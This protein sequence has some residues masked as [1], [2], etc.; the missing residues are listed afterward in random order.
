[1]EK[2][3]S[4]PLITS[5][6]KKVQENFFQ[7]FLITYCRIKKRERENKKRKGK[8]RKKE[9]KLFSM[10]WTTFTFPLLPWPQ[11]LLNKIC[12][13]WHWWSLI[14]SMP[15][16]FFLWFSISSTCWLKPVPALP[17]RPDSKPTNLALEVHISVLAFPALP[18]S[19][20]QNQNKVFW[21]E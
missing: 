10:S 6:N 3:F 7:T 8:K 20:K 16:T 9:K 11:S 5:S 1:M 2:Q 19:W 13:M 14:I 17:R 12:C 15:F 4:L 21:E 18:L